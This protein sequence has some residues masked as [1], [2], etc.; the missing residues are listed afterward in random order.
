MVKWRGGDWWR[1]NEE[2][3]L[4]PELKAAHGEKRI[5][6]EY[7]YDYTQPHETLGASCSESELRWVVLKLNSTKLG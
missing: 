2:V 4:V 6:Q 1:M 3:Y 5:W 7:E